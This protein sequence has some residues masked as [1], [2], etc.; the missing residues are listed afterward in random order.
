MS[1]STFK[2]STGIKLFIRH[3]VVLSGIL[4]SSEQF[5]GL[6]Q[7]HPCFILKDRQLCPYKYVK[8]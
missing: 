1:F 5:D 4:I 8:Y 2:F 7:V 3:P 6:V